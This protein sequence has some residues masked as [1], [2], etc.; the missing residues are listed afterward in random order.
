MA[1]ITVTKKEDLSTV[2]IVRSDNFVSTYINNARIGLS[3][4]DI[5][6]IVGHLEST[7]DGVPTSVEAVFLQMTPAYARALGDD[8]L[9]TVK[10]YE[11]LYG[12]VGRPPNDPVIPNIKK[13]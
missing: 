4:W 11:S 3:K 1:D 7:P 2:K 13:K 6:L 8:L 12:E 10:Q 9:S 5:G